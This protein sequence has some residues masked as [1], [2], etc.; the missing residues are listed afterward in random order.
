MKIA[1]RRRLAFVSLL[2]GLAFAACCV[3][4]GRPASASAS[5]L[6]PANHVFE[7]EKMGLKHL[8]SQELGQLTA[9][10]PLVDIYCAGRYVV[11]AVDKGEVHCIDSVKGTWLATSVLIDAPERLPAASGEQLFLVVR[12]KIYTFDVPKGMLSNGYDPQFGLSAAPVVY[13]GDLILSG[14]NG[15]MATLPIGGLDQTHLTSLR[16][17]I[18]YPPVVVGNRFYVTSTVSDTLMAWD[19]EG[20]RELWEWQAEKPSLI[21]SS[22]AVGEGSAYVGD[23]RGF[24]YALTAEYGQ[25]AW[26]TML[27]APIV[28]EPRI[29]D[30]KLLVLTDKPSL[31]CL[32]A[33]G[34]RQVLWTY[35]GAVRILTTSK[36]VAYVLNKDSSMAGVSLETGKELWYDPLPPDTKA[37][38]DPERPVFYIANSGGS[39]AAFQELQ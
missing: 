9:S 30:S 10:A 2:P 3:P 27:E 26:K 1:L 8:W 28:G 14:T 23:N 22:V 21:S 6:T 17:A 7:V 19:M 20:K 31:V 12:D 5:A 35:P 34:D 32:Q 16:G 36:S 13:S 37:A 11:V 33:G 39:I 18:F 38:G 25:Q 24:L 15:Y 29:V 4:A